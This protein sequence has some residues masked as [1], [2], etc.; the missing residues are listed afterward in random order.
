M[1]FLEEL[2][3]TPPAARMVLPGAI[4][5]L[6]SRHKH[7][8]VWWVFGVLPLAS[9]VAQAITERR[10]FSPPAPTHPT[11]GQAIQATASEGSW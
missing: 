7:P 8:I 6:V 3:D 1:T 4:L 10:L 9:A 5:G 11:G 2:E